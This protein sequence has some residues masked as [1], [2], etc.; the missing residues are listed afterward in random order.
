MAQKHRSLAIVVPFF[1]GIVLLACMAGSALVLGIDVGRK[2]DTIRTLETESSQI[3]SALLALVD[4]ET[5]FR[6]FALTGDASYLEPYYQA[7][8]DCGLRKIRR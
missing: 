3:Q 7:C 4:A 8:N 2:S 6:G 5:G 1:V